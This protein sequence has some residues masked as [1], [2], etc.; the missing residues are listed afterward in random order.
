MRAITPEEFD[1]IAGGVMKRMPT[2]MRRSLMGRDG[3]IDGPGVPTGGPAGGV[4]YPTTGGGWVVVAPGGPP[5]APVIIGSGGGTSA[6][7]AGGGTGG[8]TGGFAPVSAEYV[9]HVAG[10]SLSDGR[11]DY[12]DS[13]GNLVAYKDGTHPNRDSDPFDMPLNSND[14]Q[15]YHAIGVDYGSNNVGYLI[16]PTTKAGWAAATADAT[17]LF[18]SDDNTVTKLTDALAPTDQDN[19]NTPAN[20]T[21]IANKMGVGANTPLQSSQINS[22]VQNFAQISEGFKGNDPNN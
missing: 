1:Q 10:G 7:P 4:G 13:A 15:K 17:T 21:R 14:Y 3:Q 6:P 20:I 22:F 5:R 16:F 9:G 11:V 2:Q 19:P 12:F 8:G 18:D